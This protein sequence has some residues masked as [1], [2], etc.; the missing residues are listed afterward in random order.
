MM[1]FNLLLAASLPLALV[2]GC[3]IP[4]SAVHALDAQPGNEVQTS[5]Q[6]LFLAA[7]SNPSIWE[8]QDSPISC[9]K[10][11]PLART[12]NNKRHHNKHIWNKAEVGG[13]LDIWLK[14]VAYNR[15]PERV[16]KNIWPH[17]VV[18]IHCAD[19]HSTE[20]GP[21]T[22]NCC[23]KKTSPPSQKKLRIHTSFFTYL[24]AFCNR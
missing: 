11:C 13:W 17:K 7:S 22:N 3:V 16:A 15:W 1:H 5:D 21:V 8:D 10:V 9:K 24:I 20:C 2:S 4:E 18:D 19:M 6:Q 12:V 14:A 23:K